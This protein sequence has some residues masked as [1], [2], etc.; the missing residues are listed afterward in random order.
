MNSGLIAAC[1]AIAGSFVGALGSVVGTFIT[2]RHQDRRDSRARHRS[3][4]RY[5]LPSTIP[6]SAD[7][8][9]MWLFSRFFSFLSCELG[10]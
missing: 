3:I 2:Q 6:L 5:Q 8:A 9:F 10:A 4:A 1:A 7:L